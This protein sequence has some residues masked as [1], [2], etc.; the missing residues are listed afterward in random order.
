MNS[1]SIQAKECP[2][3]RSRR[4]WPDP[5]DAPDVPE[6]PVLAAFSDSP[7]S[8]SVDMHEQ[9]AGSANCRRAAALVAL[10]G[11]PSDDFARVGACTGK[12]LEDAGKIL[13]MLK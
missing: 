1:N 5:F 13:A 8:L 2:D 12:E 7:S 4:L 11:E 10:W 6:A 9:I 3:E